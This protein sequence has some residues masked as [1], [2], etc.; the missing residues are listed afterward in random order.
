M[1]K[2]T[3]CVM[4]DVFCGGDLLLAIDPLLDG[5]LHS[6][7]LRIANLEGVFSEGEDF[8]DKQDCILFAPPSRISVLKQLGI[9]VV[10]LANNHFH[11]QGTQGMLRTL[12]LLDTH[13]IGHV[14]AGNNLTEAR[15][16]WIGM[17]DDCQVGVLAYC[18][19]EPGYM[20]NLQFATDRQPGVL[21]LE[22]AQ[23]REDILAL[24]NEVDRIIVLVHW[25]KEH[26]WF[27]LSHNVQ[28]ATE[29]IRFGAHAVVGSH[30]HRPQGFFVQDACPIFM[31]L[32]NFLF[33]NFL[34]VPP[35]SVSYHSVQ[36]LENVPIT[37]RYYSPNRP[38]YKM[39]PW[40]S[41]LSLVAGLA[42]SDRGFEIEVHLSK[43][44]DR[45]AVL[46]LFRTG[47]PLGVILLKWMGSF[48]RRIHYAYFERYWRIAE[49]ILEVPGLI[50]V[51]IRSRGISLTL[52]KM[53]QLL[54]K[55][56][57]SGTV[58]HDKD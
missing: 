7:A 23:Y 56:C 55:G 25:G 12:D 45:Q 19:Y 17:C 13:G 32:G 58:K 57:A 44:Q 31:S 43:Q 36:D 9:N 18:A 39:R 16:P 11:D 14:G 27:P 21:Q 3:I 28:T 38:T 35:S 51:S 34:M 24:S 2:P 52:T 30:P 49:R 33:P 50:V 40:Q 53:F 29:M 10:S 48:Y 8:T 47:E 20:T 26:T 5:W 46:E 54:R 4:G 22:P 41:R 1:N 37:R 6:H 15:R 42:V